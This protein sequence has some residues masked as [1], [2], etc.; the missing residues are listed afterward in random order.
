MNKEKESKSL[1]DVWEWKESTYQEVA[2]L[3]IEQALEKRILDSTQSA[4]KL[5]FALSPPS[6]AQ[7]KATIIHIEN[8]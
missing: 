1:L 6:N 5:G 7:P 4:K 2:D 8:Q 3:P